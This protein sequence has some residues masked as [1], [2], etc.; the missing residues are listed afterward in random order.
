MA[1]R[2]AN[3]RTR[4]LIDSLVLE[5]PMHIVDVGANP[6][7]ARPDYD[8][9][10]SHG[11]AQLWGFE[12]NEKAFAE[13]DSV[14]DESRTYLPYAVGAPG[15]ARFYSHKISTLSSLYKFRRAAAD[16]MGK[17]HW[18]KREITE[19]EVDLVA[20]DDVDEIPSIDLLK[21]DVQGAE[22]D[23]LTGGR[24]K[25]TEAIAVIPEVA[26]YQIY[27]GQPMLRDVD[28]E[29]HE[30]G[31]VLHKILF[32]KPALLPSSQRKQLHPRLAAS[33]SI[34]GDAV[35]IRNLEDKEA[36]STEALKRLA[37]AADTVFKSFDLC[38]MCL[39]ELVRR[40]AVER[41]LPRVYVRKLPEELRIMEPAVEA[42]S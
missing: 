3:R 17:G 38:L 24:T 10:L 19:I 23:V 15:K 12:P 35:Y 27:E 16:F 36:V 42:S 34:D 4:F 14:K 32:Q 13:L 21:M 20:L 28:A 33:Q 1:D 22:L 37:L 41:R 18:Y 25:L 6:F 29:L 39:D 8:P 11:S 31:F 5:R 7:G 26:F 30:Q 40:D 9:L 2:L